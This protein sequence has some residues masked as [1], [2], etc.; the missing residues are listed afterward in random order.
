MK[1]IILEDTL[2]SLKALGHDLTTLKLIQIGGLGEDV[3]FPGEKIKTKSYD[4]AT[5]R[6][7]LLLKE[8][9]LKASFDKGKHLVQGHA[10]ALREKGSTFAIIV[11]S[12]PL[13][14][15]ELPSGCMFVQH[16]H[17]TGKAEVVG[18]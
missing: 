11:A 9:D 5:E 2:S 15:D 13:Q 10:I 17:T 18:A 12:M 16:H 14:K 6:T 4:S 3:D 1:K 8:R 7:A